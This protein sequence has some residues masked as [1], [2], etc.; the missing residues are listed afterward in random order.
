MAELDVIYVAGSG[1]SGTTVLDRV[2]GT[3][4]GV[5]S[6]N[7]LYCLLTDGV[8]NNDNCAC[9]ARFSDCGFWREVMARSFDGPAHIARVRELYD[10]IDHMHVFPQIYTGFMGGKL[11]AEVEE[12]RAWLK[13]FYLTLAELAGTRI[14]VDS[15]KVPTRALLLSQ[16]P[17]IKVHVVH[18]VRDVRAVAYAWQ[19][20]KFNPAYQR[21]LPTY[22]ALRTARFWYARN[23]FSE[24]LARRSTTY[25]RVSY[26][27]YCARPREVLSDLVRRLE[28]V[29]GRDL[30][31]AADG[32]L[33]LQSFHS[34]GGNPDRFRNGPT[35][36]RLDTAWVEKLRPATRRALTVL[37]YPLL[38]RYGYLGRLRPDR[39]VVE[40]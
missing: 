8:E 15:S 30:A 6:F 19:K 40:A 36:L 35:Q 2:L 38:A 14:L 4:E 3:L 22:D 20:E 29:A 10:R 18:V 17:G 39:L 7:E 1:R 26:E 23:L 5:T 33:D 9:G 12:Y 21:M 31:F 13:R 16:I 28:P 24:L 32:S 11:R 25:M 27:A 34:I 37:G